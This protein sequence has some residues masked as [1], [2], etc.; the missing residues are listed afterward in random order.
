MG[1]LPVDWRF[2]WTVG[3]TVQYPLLDFGTADARRLQADQATLEQLANYRRTVLVAVQQVDDALTGY[4][5][6][7][8]RLRGLD[9][10]VAAA[11][12]AVDL[13]TQRYDRG[14]I[15]FLNVVDAERALFALQDQRAVSERAA[16]D[17][18]VS[19]C[20]NL[21]GGWQGFPPPPPLRQPLPAVLATLR[22]ATGRS[23]RPL[24]G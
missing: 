1:R 5:A 11:A 6:E 17:D 13:A 8:G 16:V 18:F 15:D 22:D 10:A 14:I 24:G 20:Q 19:V 2:I 9:R 23:E 4:A 7:R 21:G 3:P 12:R